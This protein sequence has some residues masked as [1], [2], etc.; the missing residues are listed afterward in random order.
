MSFVHGMN[1]RRKVRNALSLGQKI[2]AHTFHASSPTTRWPHR[3]FVRP[4]SSKIFRAR[5]RKF[6]KHVAWSDAHV[7]IAAEQT[8]ERT[9]EKVRTRAPLQK[10]NLYCYKKLDEKDPTRQRPTLQTGGV[11]SEGTH[12]STNNAQNAVKET[13]HIQ[14]VYIIHVHATNDRSKIPQNAHRCN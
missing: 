10:F 8:N 4:P 7:H 14:Q 5:A 11:K 2:S 13:T 3:R 9:S 6:T 12:G 1:A